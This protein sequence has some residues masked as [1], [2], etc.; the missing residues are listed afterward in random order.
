M[1]VHKFIKMHF[2]DTVALLY[3]N[4]ISLKLYI[5][6]QTDMESDLGKVNGN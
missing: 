2:T 4:I 5:L 6:L 3:C 1:A